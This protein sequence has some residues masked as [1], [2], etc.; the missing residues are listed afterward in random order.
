VAGN[1]TNFSINKR[2]H[3]NERSGELMTFFT[4]SYFGA[5]T[6]FFNG[7]NTVSLVTKPGTVSIDNH[8]AFVS[9]SNIAPTLQL[10]DY[11]AMLTLKNLI[12]EN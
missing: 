9:I 10:T 4:N 8:S 1:N 2:Q 3:H 6:G 12:P 7:T 5:G 11:A